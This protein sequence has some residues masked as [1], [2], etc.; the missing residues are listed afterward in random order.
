[1]LIT[2]PLATDAHLGE[3]EKVAIQMLA[4]TSASEKNSGKGHK[5]SFSQRGVQMTMSILF[6]TKMNEIKYMSN[7]AA[8]Y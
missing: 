1:M 7:N 3:D 8:W 5:V 4:Q 6:L 2:D